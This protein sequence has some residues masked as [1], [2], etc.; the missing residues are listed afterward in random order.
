MYMYLYSVHDIVIVK[1]SWLPYTSAADN[2]N[3]MK[4]VSSCGIRVALVLD[5]IFNILEIS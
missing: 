2:I 4:A 5:N 3:E 1:N